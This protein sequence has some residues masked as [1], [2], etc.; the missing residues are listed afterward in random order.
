MSQKNDKICFCFGYS[1]EDIE[2]DFLKNNAS[3]IMQSIVSAKQNG[4][5]ECAQKN[6]SGR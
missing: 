4:Q 3:L 5:C 2:A 1:Q 6:P